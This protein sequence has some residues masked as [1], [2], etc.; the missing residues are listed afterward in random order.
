MSLDTPQIKRELDEAE[1]LRERLF[2]LQAVLEFNNEDGG[3]STMIDYLHTLY[4]LIEKEHVIYTRFCL[5]DTV[6]AHRAIAKLDAYK[7]MDLLGEIDEKNLATIYP[8]LKK[9]LKEVIKETSGDDFNDEDFED[10]FNI[11]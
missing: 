1:F 11:W 7:M 8:T 3:A 2:N 9:N 4:A 10:D 6:E 5:I